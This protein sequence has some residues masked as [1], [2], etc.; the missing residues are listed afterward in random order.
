M[1]FCFEYVVLQQITPDTIPYLK[2]LIEEHHNVLQ[3]GW[4]RKVVLLTFVMVMAAI[5]ESKI[6]WGLGLQDGCHI[7]MAKSKQCNVPLY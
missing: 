2:I 3:H 5:L 7:A 4:Y 1:R 6:L